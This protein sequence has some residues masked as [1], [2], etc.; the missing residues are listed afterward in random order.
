MCFTGHRELPKNKLDI[1]GNRIEEE[2]DFL[3]KK[4]YCNF[5]SGGALGFDLF[6]AQIVLR[7]KQ[8][9]PHINLILILPCKE[10]TKYW[11]KSNIEIYDTVKSK[12]DKIMY[13]SEF[14]YRGCMHKRNRKLV[15]TAS[16]CICYL[17]K[18]SG[19]TFYTVNYAESKGLKLINIAK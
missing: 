9:Y 19:G 18:N 4:G 2:V 8:K 3:I 7:L 6:A 12:A 1:I 17:E 10:Q 15:D 14:Y 16:V 11:E 5:V 13:T